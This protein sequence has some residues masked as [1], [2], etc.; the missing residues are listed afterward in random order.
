MRTLT[1]LSIFTLLGGLTAAACGEANA[2]GS[3]SS[4]HHINDAVVLDASGLDG[5]LHDGAVDVPACR[6]GVDNDQD[7]L[8]DWPDDPGCTDADDVDE[9]NPPYCGLT[10]EGEMIP[11][12]TIPPTGH[13]V[14]T[15]DN[16]VSHYQGSCGGSGAPELVFSL[17]ILGNTSGVLINTIG[18]P[19]LLDTV[20]YVR[21]DTCDTPNTEIECAASTVGGGGVEVALEDPQ[22]GEYFIFIDGVTPGAAGQFLLEVR[23]LI[24]EGAPCDPADQTLVCTPGLICV[25]QPSICTV[26][27]CSD[28]IDNDGDGI[29][30][31]PAEPGCESALDHTEDD[32]CPGAGCPACADG[33]DND[34]D[35][36][37]D[38]PNDPGCSCAGDPIELDEC[39]PGLELTELPV[40]GIA[41]GTVDPAELSLSTGSCGYN[42]G[43][44]VVFPLSLPFGAVEVD[45]S[46]QM[47]GWNAYPNVYVRQGDCAAG[48]ELGCAGSYNNPE[49]LQLTNL[50]AGDYF[51]FADSIDIWMAD[52]FTLT[53]QVKLPVG[54]VCELGNPLKQC[55]AG[56]TCQDV[57]GTFE[58]VPTACNNGVDDDS[59]GY[60]DYPNDPGCTD[61]GDNDE[62]DSC[63]PVNNPAA[64]PVCFNGA[65]DDGDGLTDYPNDPGCAA[66]S[67]GNEIDECYPG[68]QVGVLPPSG[69]VTATLYDSDPSHTSPTCQ[70]WSVSEH[71]YA[72]ELPYGAAQLDVSMSTTQMEPILYVRHGNCA[73]GAELSCQYTWQPPAVNHLN[74]V[75][76]GTVFLF[77]DANFLYQPASSYTLSVTVGQPVGASCVLGSPLQGCGLGSTCQ[78]IGGGVYQCVGAACNNGVDDDG[79]GYVDF[80]NDPGCTDISDNDEIDSCDPVNNPAACPACF[81]NSDD[82]ADG[83]TDFPADLGCSSAADNSELNECQPGQPFTNITPT[84]NAIGSPSGMDLH[85]GSCQYGGYPEDVYLLHLTQPAAQV[86]IS[87]QGN[88]DYEPVVYVRRDSCASSAAEI[89]CA[90]AGAPNWDRAEL[91]LYN[92]APGHLFLF[93]DSNY[94]GITGQYSLSVT[95]TLSSGASC[96]PTSTV[97]VCPPGTTCTDPGTGH[98]CQ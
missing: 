87:L 60:V 3:D 33:V 16:G 68:L 83:L 77:A 90:A 39:L 17:T 35:G 59:D 96:I 15:T 56:G 67:D 75:P 34:G 9:G 66:A 24:P 80:P 71:V 92:V 30:D 65:D 54:A 98:V 79:D 94:Q 44:E 12:R 62:I 5:A 61:I 72:L 42:S 36:F 23:G 37:T 52:T 88:M 81:N 51:V 13:L 47:G 19:T 84:G 22:P 4:T 89:G 45:I 86:D 6:D 85:Q 97:V 10:A 14:Q 27:L 21:Q 49:T 28:G 82:D 91:T 7:G 20:V 40:S 70:T 11:I 2:P 78:D 58:C 53:V 46:M 74:N 93:A 38:W 41:T 50:T 69:S 8:T 63:D 76:A 95:A 32:T 43:Q 48:V 26:P 29:T 64:C 73:L 18:T 57:G 25:G 55:A 31:F 1:A